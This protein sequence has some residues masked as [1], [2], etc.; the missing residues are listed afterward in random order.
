M[1]SPIKTMLCAL[2]LVLTG[3]WAA[4]LVG[5]GP[6]DR[7]APSTDWATEAP[8]ADT[9]SRAAGPVSIDFDVRNPSAHSRSGAL[10]WV[11]LAAP[12]GAL[13]DP[14]HIT[15][16]DRDT[17][18]ELLWGVLPSDIAYHP[19]GSVSRV[20]LHF[21][22]S[23]TASAT[24]RYTAVL[25]Q[26]PSVGGS[27]MPDSVQGEWVI[28]DDT[29]LDAEYQVHIDDSVYTQSDGVYYLYIVNSPVREVRAYG[30]A[31]T[32]VGG[33]QLDPDQESFQM[34][35][36]K[37]S[38]LDIERSPLVTRVHLTYDRPEIV[39]WGPA[40]ATIQQIARIVDYISADLTLT[41]V[42]G[43]PMVDVQ[44]RRVIDERFWNHN[45]FVEEFT[46]LQGGSA[47]WDGPLEVEYGTELGLVHAPTTMG[48]NWPL[49]DGGW[50]GINVGAN[51]NPTVADLDGDGDLD[52]VVGGADGTIEALENVGDSTS[53]R[54]VRNVS[55]EG[56]LPHP[57]LLK[58]ALGDV[59]GDGDADLLIGQTDGTMR[60]Y[61]NDGSAA[62]PPVWTPITTHFAGVDLGDASA[63]SFGDANGDGLLDVIAGNEAGTLALFIN[64]GTRT[65]PS[66]QR[67]DRWVAH[68]N[69]GPT[70]SPSELWASPFLSDVDWDG[71]V[72]L[73]IGSSD[74]KITMFRNVGTRAVPSWTYLECAIFMAWSYA[75]RGQNATPVMADVDGDHD[76]DLL[77]GIQNG[78][79]Q[80]YHFAGN[81]TPYRGRYNVQPLLNGTYRLMRDKDGNDG[82]FVVLGYAN[83]WR[84]YYVLSNPRTGDAVIRYMPDF[85]RLA[86][87]QEYWGDR[88]PYSG[89]NVS[90][91]P[92]DAVAN[93][94]V[95]RAEISTNVFTRGISG[96]TFLSQTG[97]SSGFVMQPMT[98]CVYDT[99]DVMLLTRR[100]TDPFGYEP[101]VEDLRVPLEVVGL[102]DLIIEDMRLNPVL[103]GD[104]EPTTLDIKVTNYGS[105]DVKGVELEILKILTTDDF[106]VH[107]SDSFGPYDLPAWSTQTLRIPQ[108]TLFLMG[109][110]LTVTAVLDPSNKIS[111]MDESN[112]ARTLSPVVQPYSIPWSDS[113]PATTSPNTS[114]Q[115][116]L[117]VRGDGKLYA[118]WETSQ[119]LEEIDIEGAAYD[120]ATGTWSAVETLV[121]GSHYAVDPALAVSGQKVYLAYSSNIRE[122]LDYLRTTSAYWYWGEK[123]DLWVR[124]WQAGT[125]TAKRQVT[126]AEAW[127][128]SDQT[129][130]LFYGAGRMR[131]V[132][133]NTHF[134]FYVGGNQMNNIPF[135]RCDVRMATDLAGGGWDSGNTTVTNA[136]GS[137]AWW[138]GPQAA[139]EGDTLYW[140]V[141]E[142]EV[143]NAQ[144]D[145][146]AEAR[147]ATGLV[148]SV[149]LTSTGGVDEVRP[150][151]ASSATGAR[152]LV[153]YETTRNG[154][155]DI[156]A[157]WRTGD[158]GDLT[159]WSAETLLTTDPASDM[160]PAV[161]SDGKGNYW[162]A[163]ESYRTGNKDI[164]MSRFDGTTWYGPF[165]V[166]S[167]PGSD[168]QAAIAV[169]AATGRVYV[170]W[171][172][173]RNRFGNKD[174]YVRSYLATPPTI[175]LDGTLPSTID[176]DSELNVP[177]AL[178]DA[179]GDL[180][181][182]VW[183]WGDGTIATEQAT[184]LN[185]GLHVFAQ[186]GIYH[187]TAVA[188]DQYGLE[189]APISF[190]VVV[191]NVPP[192]ANLAG[193]L[194]TVEDQE[195]A[196]DASASTDTPSDVGGLAVK[197]DLGDGTTKGPLPLATA[198]VQRH[199]YT[200][201]GNYTVKATV[202]DN[203][204]D[205]ATAE[206][207]VTVTNLPPVVTEA[208]ARKTELSEDQAG[209][210]G[211]RASDT[212]SDAGRGLSYKWDWGDGSWS[213]TLQDTVATHAYAQA[214]TYTAALHAYDDDGGDG[215]KTVE[216]TVGNLAP[217]VTVDG[218]AMVEEDSPVSL[219]AVGH[220]TPSDMPLLEY[221]FLW[222]D[223]TTTDWAAEAT[224]THAYA[225][226]KTY[227]VS[228][229]V[230][231]DDL[232]SGTATFYV[233]VTNVAPI[234]K[235]EASRPQVNEGEE[236]TFD[237]NGSTDTPSD[238][239]ELRYSWDLGGGEIQTGRV[240]TYTFRDAGMH[241]VELTVTDDDGATSRT[242]VDVIVTNR[243]PRAV[244]SVN[245]TSVKVGQ[246]ITLSAAGS[247]DDPWDV[248]GLTYV[249]RTGD[250]GTVNS[251]SGAYIYSFPGT[252]T[253]TLSVKDGDGGEGKWTTEV[254]VK[255]ADEEPAGGGGNAWTVYAAAA[256]AAV[257]VLLLAVFVMMRRRGGEKGEVESPSQAQIPELKVDE[258]EPDGG[259]PKE[260]E[261][262]ELG[263]T[264]MTKDKGPE[265]GA[266]PMPDEEE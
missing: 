22:D 95:T 45:G 244:G 83:E 18:S 205:S 212:P 127:N 137:Q 139:P 180:H 75:W 77:M 247:T 265:L 112:N 59:D 3:P 32:R 251:A 136:A 259:L 167:D 126:S 147:S 204:G 129:P 87:K 36:G 80:Y 97:I 123:F 186:A 234:A 57:R 84:G 16:K 94:L 60:L 114:L 72:D 53:P 101:E 188:H 243:P 217:T 43:V 65:A 191:R 229:K 51:A 181:D 23:W 153:A 252:Y 150:A 174:I 175:A 5:T 115:C 55:W 33:N 194:T 225:A 170:G 35:W 172:T 254:I 138:G 90:Y 161:A 9:G 106:I 187:I 56:G 78:S 128:D 266:T 98:A 235:A 176:E 237:A 192:V 119:G 10:A 125:W 4:A 108:S 198:A 246:A 67:D 168:E 208:Y 218:P 215:F 109:K 82:P 148:R 226:A 100:Q 173:D 152:A 41:F 177:L 88:Y 264:P 184:T 185:F 11:D 197:W 245:P 232:A 203:D 135:Q 117:V 220:D 102:T 66:W 196:F 156:A 48:P 157:R 1:R 149:A 58:P 219:T 248:G 124:E 61:R 26:T 13:T 113:T 140:V 27:P 85:D 120:P 209:E 81:S 8:A 42:R 111:E 211:G 143:S 68:L 37:H 52:M 39:H 183:D 107:G 145:I 89:G 227:V 200:K 207:N 141:Y 263:A 122:L 222:G 76:M 210:F 31:L 110:N 261:G 249:W 49:T 47:Q 54:M 21:T 7:A 71:R 165:Q 14:D 242:T 159:A 30:Q 104:G 262:P 164:F 206:L 133:R 162:V 214:G 79:V 12:P 190:D 34:W 63:P 144:W 146:V 29:T 223:G 179:E 163:W 2:M 118:V 240:V 44:N 103:P 238:L 189:S 257:L 38:T 239:P 69:S 228:V 166:T 73:L 193:D 154:N 15:L 169:D 74:G 195:A 255:A 46:A 91:Y 260:P 202:I 86:Y 221:W 250:G 216:V 105:T 134:D 28:V 155:R 96:G 93:E 20:K 25:G 160:K 213:A 233:T 231:D 50:Q 40:G 19:D 236:V 142:T 116:D 199:M 121:T 224:A 201:S 62:G 151:I 230:R 132:F 171:E 130:D 131:A 99:R 158:A 6:Q 178:A 182:I 256:G 241:T 24:R 92:Y 17:H 258:L 64:K 70:K 253:V